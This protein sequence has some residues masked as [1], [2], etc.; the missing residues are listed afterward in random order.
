MPSLTLAKP[1]RLGNAALTIG[2]GAFGSGIVRAPNANI[3][4]GAN[5]TWRGQLAAQRVI[6]QEGSVVSA[7]TRL[8]K[9]SDPDKV[10]EDEL[11]TIIVNEIVVVLADGASIADAQAA[12]DAAGGRLTGYIPNLDMAKIEVETETVDALLDLIDQLESAGLPFVEVAFPN[13][14]TEIIGT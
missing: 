10:V 12:A 13:G 4:L 8:E 1:A 6:L 3:V 5:S 14:I 7:T 9:P 2:E 11:G